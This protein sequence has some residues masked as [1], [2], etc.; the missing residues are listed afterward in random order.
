MAGMFYF[1]EAFNQPIGNWNTAKVTDM[2]SMFLKATAFNQGIGLWNT[3]S[4][5]NMGLVLRSVK[6]A[7]WYVGRFRS[8]IWGGQKEQKRKP[9]Q[10]ST[11]RNASKCPPPWS[12]FHGTQGDLSLNRKLDLLPTPRRTGHVSQKYVIRRTLHQRPT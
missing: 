2:S 4:V 6:R 12:S 1:A 7:A 10:S 3:G 5:T 9:N 8:A 11:P